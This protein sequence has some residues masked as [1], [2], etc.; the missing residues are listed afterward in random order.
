MPTW[1]PP[2]R[3]PTLICQ[4]YQ[5]PW[6]LERSFKIEQGHGL[7]A[8]RY[9]L[10]VPAEAIS[11]AC[12]DAIMRD[13]GMPAD[14]PGLIER[15]NNELSRA[16]TVYLGYEGGLK[17][18]GSLRLYFE[19]WDEIVSRLRATPA[20]VIIGWAA[21]DRPAWEMLVGYK[22]RVDGIIS[23][24]RTSLYRS[25]YYVQPMLPQAEILEKSGRILLRSGMEPDLQA[26]LIDVMAMI[27]SSGPDIE[28][29]FLQARE[30]DSPR[31]SIDLCVHRYNLRLKD[32]ELKLGPI[33]QCCLGSP[34]ALSDCLQGRRSDGWITHLSAGRSRNGA[35]YICLYY[36]PLDRSEPLV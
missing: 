5:L 35:A 17:N 31:Y 13:M 32:L 20:S 14:E 27:L 21:T 36:E 19:F 22:W 18:G 10:G 7:L 34:L 3:L 15:L 1:V 24:S 12:L 11:S 16:S 33:L 4:H 9:V 30:N 28:P 6:V 2:E 29:V 23:K 8:D 25:D 26:M